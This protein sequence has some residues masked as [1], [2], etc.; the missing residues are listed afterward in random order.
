MAETAPETSSRH[1]SS[2][3]RTLLDVRST[4]NSAASSRVH[5]AN[6]IS[7]ILDCYN[8]CTE[9][10]RREAR[11]QYEDAHQSRVPSIRCWQ[12]GRAKCA[13]IFSS[14]VHRAYRESTN[15]M[16]LKSH[17]Q[18]H[19]RLQSFVISIFTTVT[20]VKW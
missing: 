20:R 6:F 7:R 8:I 11:R 4:M 15:A 5:I 2:C 17:S 18:S 19:G 3:R 14:M 1:V 13:L 9:V 10:Q 16:G 12:S